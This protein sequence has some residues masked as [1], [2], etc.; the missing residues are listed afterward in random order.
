MLIFL[1]IRKSHSKSAHEGGDYR[2]D[3]LS[4]S[5]NGTMVSADCIRKKWKDGKLVRDD[6]NFLQAESTTVD[7]LSAF[8]FMRTLPFSSWEIGHVHTA[9]IFSG[10]RKELLTIK[11]MG[12]EDLEYDNKTYKC[13]HIKFKF[14]SDG[15]KRPWKILKQ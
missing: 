5:Y 7:M 4:Y 3:Y 15:R 2:Y 8:F 10:K 6:K 9:N 1:W 12:K 13:Y 11:Y 14:T